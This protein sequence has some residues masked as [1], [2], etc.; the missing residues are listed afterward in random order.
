M[1]CKMPVNLG[2]KLGGGG[3]D[4]FKRRFQFGKLLATTP[5]GDVAERVFRRIKLVMLANGVSNSPKFPAM[6]A[7]ATTSLLPLGSIPHFA[8]GDLT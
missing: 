3:A 1:L 8:S 7:F 4:S 5:P 6:I 2:Y